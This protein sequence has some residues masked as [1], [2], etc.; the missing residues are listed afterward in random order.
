MAETINPL[1]AK[2]SKGWIATFGAAC[3]VICLPFTAQQE[4]LRLKSYL[5]PVGV[6]T[7]CYGETQG[8]GPGVIKTADDCKEMLSSRL[9]FFAWQVN[10]LVK[11]PIN[12][13]TLAAFSSMAYNVGIDN[14][15]NSNLLK[16]LNA[17]D[18]V[19]ACNELPRW[20]RA[21]GKILPGLTK[22]RLAEQKLCLQGTQ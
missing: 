8:A 18:V 13:P 5:D 17:G 22:R 20:N 12:P 6:W 7:V 11:V 21:K 4:G 9:G 10:S 16:K 15:K 1:P 19:G 2:G 3:M 14:F